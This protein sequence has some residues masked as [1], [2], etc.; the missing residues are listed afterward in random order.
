MEVCFGLSVPVFLLPLLSC[1]LASWRFWFSA[2]TWKA[3]QLLHA[4]GTEFEASGVHSGHYW[5]HYLA[6]RASHLLVGRVPNACMYLLLANFPTSPQCGV[7]RGLPSGTV[8][9]GLCPIHV[10][11][12]SFL[13]SCKY[14]VYS[15]SNT[16]PGGFGNSGEENT[17]VSWRGGLTQVGPAS[18][19][20]NH[21]R[22]LSSKLPHTPLPGSP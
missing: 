20:E 6:L 2:G 11:Y 14:A 3:L 7:S 13:F 19:P 10:G 18:Q 1:S 4:S 5:K 17:R 22:C 21:S 8:G 16:G 12:F 9:S 15:C